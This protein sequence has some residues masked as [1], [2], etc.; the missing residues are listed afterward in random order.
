M[1]LPAFE[2]ESERGK[3]ARGSG[4][5]RATEVKSADFSVKPLHSLSGIGIS[6]SAV[7]F[8]PGAEW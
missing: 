3:E 1:S 5:D 4:T 2:F 8:P 7:L 6:F